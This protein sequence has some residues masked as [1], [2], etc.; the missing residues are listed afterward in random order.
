MISAIIITRNEERNI[1]RT[2]ASLCDPSIAEI[3]VSDSNSSDKTQEIVRAEA[4]KDHRIR[5]SSYSDPP[6]TA[7]RGRN[8]GAKLAKKKSKY[9]LFIDGDMQLQDGFIEAGIKALEAEKGL[10]AVAGQMHNYFYKGYGQFSHAQTNYYK[11][12]EHKPGG[13]LLL[14][15]KDFYSLGG[16]NP[17]LIVNEESE[18]IYRL[19]CIGRSFSRISVDMV[20]HHTEIP[21]SK[22]RLKERLYDRKV[23][24]LS[25]NV[26]LGFRDFGYLKVVIKDNRYTFISAITLISSSIFA[27]VIPLVSFAI[28]ASMLTFVSIKCKSVKVAANYLVYGVGLLVGIIF[29]WC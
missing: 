23:T 27:F 9:L 20:I 21:I 5:L 8:E 1:S 12:N 11:I 24:A 15:A 22:R 2:L 26:M 14:I 19:N 4:D 10:S 28:M 18:F 16:F 3:I 17:E 29:S 7:A 13:A 6:F 25:K